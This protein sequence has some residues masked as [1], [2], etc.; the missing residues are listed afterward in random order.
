MTQLRNM[1]YFN[2][3]DEVAMRFP[4]YTSKGGRTISP[5]SYRNAAEAADWKMAVGSSLMPTPSSDV[6]R[7]FEQGLA[8]FF[9]GQRQ[10]TPENWQKFIDDFMRMG[11]EAWNQEGIEFAEESNL[12]VD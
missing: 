10:L 7:F 3:A 4:D 8:E 5:I 11:G 12:V 2:T 9:S 1:V 6:Q